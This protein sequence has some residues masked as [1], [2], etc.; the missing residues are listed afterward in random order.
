MAHRHTDDD[1]ELHGPDL[2]ADAAPIK[3][4]LLVCEECR[5]RLAGWYGY[6]RAIRAALWRLP[7]IALPTGA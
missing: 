1:L 4:H 6:V 5:G 3:D 2:L 7:A